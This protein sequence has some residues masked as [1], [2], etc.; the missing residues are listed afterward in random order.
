MP[1]YL[2]RR[3]RDTEWAESAPCISPR[4]IE[5]FHFEIREIRAALEGGLR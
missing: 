2:E 4:E 3:V 5:I 1:T